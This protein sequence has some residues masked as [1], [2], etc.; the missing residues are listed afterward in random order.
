MQSEP[1]TNSD[2]NRQYE[3]HPKAGFL[4]KQLKTKHMIHWFFHQVGVIDV[5]A[6]FGK[7]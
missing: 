2:K 6:I 1:F 5:F 3:T 4:R 7:K